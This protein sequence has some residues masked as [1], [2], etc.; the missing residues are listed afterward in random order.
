[1]TGVQTCALPISPSPP[2]TDAQTSQTAALRTAMTWETQE[3]APRHA[4][5]GAQDLTAAERLL[6]TAIP[7]PA[8]AAAAHRRGA[9]NTDPASTRS[10]AASASASGNAFTSDGFHHYLSQLLPESLRRYSHLLSRR[11]R[12]ALAA[13]LALAIPVLLWWSSRTPSM[14]SWLRGF[15]SVLQGSGGGGGGLGKLWGPVLVVVAFFVCFI[16]AL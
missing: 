8:A 3:G 10:S 13:L 15:L 16:V 12:E 1:M 11:R 9:A 6:P 4:A 7:S 2:P 5:A 14:R